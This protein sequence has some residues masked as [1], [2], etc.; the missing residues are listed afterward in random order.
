MSEC[1]CCPDINSATTGTHT[2]DCSRLH[3]TVQTAVPA[4]A[5]VCS[6]QEGAPDLFNK[7]IQIPL[8]LNE[9]FIVSRPV[10]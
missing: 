7:K 5:L 10:L 3:V 2:V 9:A 8:R 6:L 1:E 4:H